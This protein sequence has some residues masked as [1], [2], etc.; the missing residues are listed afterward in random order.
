MSWEDILKRNLTV[1][2]AVG[3]IN[4]VLSEYENVEIESTRRLSE[5]YPF[6][7]IKDIYDALFYIDKYEPDSGGKNTVEYVIMCNVGNSRGILFSTRLDDDTKEMIKFFKKVANLSFID[8][9][10][11]VKDFFTS[12]SEDSMGEPRRWLEWVGKIQ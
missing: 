10:A 2:E 8:K 3:E 4:D 9:L 12:I 7:E 6:Q 11:E 1:I 5:D